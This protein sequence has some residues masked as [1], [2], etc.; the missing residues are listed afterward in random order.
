MVA[1]TDKYDLS[2]DNMEALA[3][4]WL[5]ARTL[6]GLPGNLSGQWCITDIHHNKTEA[7]KWQKKFSWI[8]LI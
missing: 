6:S 7:K 1:S 2:G 3:F 4:A 8:L 5:A